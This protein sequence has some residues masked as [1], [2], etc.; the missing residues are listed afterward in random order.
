MEI[1]DGSDSVPEG[2]AKVSSSGEDFITCVIG[3][4]IILVMFMVH[5]EAFTW[6][7]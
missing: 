6:F 4:M 3:S 7:I 1:S 5:L 2:L